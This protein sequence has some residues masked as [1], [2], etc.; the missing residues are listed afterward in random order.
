MELLTIKKKEAHS[1]CLRTAVGQAEKPDSRW[2]P[3]RARRELC[4]AAGARGQLRGVGIG[5]P[6][7]KKNAARP[8]CHRRTD[9]DK[10]EETPVLCVHNTRFSA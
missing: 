8:V 4:G 5:D 1:R 2:P 9:T 7:C 10:K 3:I 6:V